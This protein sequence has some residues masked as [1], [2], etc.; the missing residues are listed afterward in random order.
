MKKPA[1][2]AKE[3]RADLRLYGRYCE[4]YTVQA[5]AHGRA[6][7][8]HEFVMSLNPLFRGPAFRWEGLEAMAARMA[9][10]TAYQGFSDRVW[11]LYRPL[12][13]EDAA[14]T[15]RIVVKEL[16]DQS[17]VQTWLPLPAPPEVP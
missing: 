14:R 16:L 4:K 10:A 6:V 2:T 17:G 12:I 15:A 1:K 7:A 5:Q 9:R 8:T 13:E 3:I 11:A